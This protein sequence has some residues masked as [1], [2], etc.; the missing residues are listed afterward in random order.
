MASI[1]KVNDTTVKSIF[2]STFLLTNKRE[3]IMN[4]SFTITKKNC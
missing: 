1:I 3:L 2:A 4:S